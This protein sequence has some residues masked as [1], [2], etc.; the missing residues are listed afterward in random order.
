MAKTLIGTRIAAIY[1]LQAEWMDPKLDELGITW[2]TFQLLTTV[3]NAGERASQVEVAGLL[4]RQ[5]EVRH[6]RRREVLMRV[7]DER[8]QLARTEFVGDFGQR[9]PVHRVLF[10]IGC[11]PVADD[12]AE[13]FEQ[14]VAATS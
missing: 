7:A 10:G 12:A 6:V 1:E 4:L 8:L 13:V 11:Q 14:L 5:I 9:L 3:A 2:S